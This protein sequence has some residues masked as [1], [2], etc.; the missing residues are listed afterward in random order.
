M[1][2]IYLRICLFLVG[3]VFFCCCKELKKKNVTAFSKHIGKAYH[4][5]QRYQFKWTNTISPA[6]LIDTK[7]FRDELVRFKLEK[8]KRA[9]GDDEEMF[10]CTDKDDIGM[11]SFLA[12]TIDNPDVNIFVFYIHFNYNFNLIYIRLSYKFK[13]TY[14]IKY[15][16]LSLSNYF[17]LI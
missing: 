16:F 9:D 3:L 5:S 12:H 11:T 14:P 1:I 7:K 2:F 4:I 13:S 10:D 6:V 15:G 8:I 17:S